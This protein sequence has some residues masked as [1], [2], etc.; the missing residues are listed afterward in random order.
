MDT[1]QCRGGWY[2]WTLALGAT[3]VLLT[4]MIFLK[5]QVF[6]SLGAFGILAA[7]VVVLVWQWRSR[8]FAGLLNGDDRV[9]EW[10]DEDDRPVCIGEAAIYANDRFLCWA[11]RR[12][13]LKRAEYNP[14]KSIFKF[15]I[16]YPAAGFLPWK[17]KVSLKITVPPEAVEAALEAQNFFAPRAQNHRRH[18]VDPSPPGQEHEG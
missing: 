5:H 13:V 14:K 8:C 11:G 6:I 7:G 9:A 3:A 15:V 17:C 12:A 16:L 1:K 2:R 10:L 4:G 18:S